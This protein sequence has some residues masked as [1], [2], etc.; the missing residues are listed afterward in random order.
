MAD[1][2]AAGM[3][4]AVMA[5]DGTKTVEATAH[6]PFRKAGLHHCFRLVQANGEWVECA[7]HHRL[8]T[9]DGW[10]RLSELLQR[11]GS[12][13]LESNSEPVQLVHDEDGRNFAE[14]ASG[15]PDGCFQDCR[16]YGEQLLCEKEGVRFCLQSLD[17]ALPHSRSS[18]DWDGDLLAHT[19]M[20]QA[21]S[22]L[23]SSS[24][25]LPIRADP[26]VVYAEKGVD[27]V[28]RLMCG[29]RQNEPQ[30]LFGLA[31][32]PQSFLEPSRVCH[33]ENQRV[34]S[35]ISPIAGN[36][37]I[38]VEY[39]GRKP[40]YDF[41]VD[42]W[43][44]YVAGGLVHHNTQAGAAELATH[45]TGLYP[46][47]WDGRRW[48]RPVKAWAGGK[49]SLS[50]RDSV[51]E[52]LL[53]PSSARGTGMI[54]K[55]NIL[56]ISTARGVPGGVDTVVVRHASG[57]SSTINFKS[58]DQGRERW[59][60]ATRDIVWLDEEPSEEIYVE[61]LS[62]T[63]ATGGMLYMTATPLLGMSK[64][65][66]RFLMEPSSDRSDTN[67]TIDDAE[68]ISPE[69][70]AQ[71]I[72][73]YPAH[74]RKA[75]TLGEPSLG[76]GQIF[77]VDENIIKVKAFPIPDHWTVIGAL[78]FGWDH[79][80]AAVRLAWDRD[81]DAVYVTHAYKMREAV[82][83]VHIA[84]LRNWGEK[85]LWAWPHDGLQHD[86]GA[87][88]QIAE[89]YRRGGLRMLPERAQYAGE[90][91]NSVEAGIS[92][93]LERMETE[94]LK[95]FD[96]LGEF[97][98]EFRLYHRKDGRVVKEFDDILASCRYGLMSLRFARPVK[99][100]K[101]KRPAPMLTGRG[102]GTTAWMG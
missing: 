38:S 69:Q 99:G 41:T 90:R 52:K 46:M 70:R 37:I 15:Y 8:L 19:N 94:R 97:F 9:S 10:L 14:T 92:D 53:G 87:G 79:P 82:P 88:I 91:G 72:A 86:K 25:V 16:R 68:H 65:V 57:G 31:F 78:D 58:Y 100:E 96:H 36:R 20:R 5:W 4:F 48:S 42:I 24:D 21:D 35:V 28:F 83:A 43:H 77:P 60:A 11:Y 3:P 75:R 101:P 51:V 26:S 85:M 67:M 32:G 50:V 64:V 23:L 30:S 84:T 45:A 62:R 93:M 71:I 59:Q 1:L 81:T 44:N 47:W 18:F 39:I 95:V 13:H 61:A 89:Q 17:G 40:V 56:H 12:S 27:K 2:M 63:N 98:E 54:P 7:D 55:A 29:S 49:D 73:S 22:A 34:P 80:T 6:A 66:R 74:E 33:Q 76:S 102:P